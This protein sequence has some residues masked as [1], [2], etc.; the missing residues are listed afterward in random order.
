MAILEEEVWTGLGGNKIQHFEKLGYEIPRRIGRDGK[1]SVPKKLKILVK[2]KDLTES[3]TQLVTKICDDCG[4]QIPNKKYGDIILSRKLGDGRDRCHP[5]GMIYANNKQKNNVK[6][7]NSLE[8]Y[9]KNNQKEYLINEFS[10]K[11]IKRPNE[12]SSGSE[13]KYLWDCF[14]CKGEYSSQVYSRTVGSGCPYCSGRKVLIGFND[15]WTTHPELAKLLKD[16]KRGFEVTHGS[17]KKEIFVC[18]R[19]GYEQSKMLGNVSRQGFSC[20]RCSDGIKYPEK[21]LISFLDQLNLDYEPQKI[22][23]W[24]NNKRYD[25]YIRS[26]NMIIEVHGEQHYSGIG[27]SNLSGKTVKDEQKNDKYKYEMAKANNINEFIVL[28]CR[29]SNLNFIRNSILNSK[30]YEIFDL[31]RINWLKCHEFACGTIVKIISDLWNDG[32]K[33]TTEIGTILKMDSA[34]ISKYLKQGNTLGWCTYN[35]EEVKKATGQKISKSLRKKPVIQLTKDGEYL[36][37]WGSPTEAEKEMGMFRGAVSGVC[38]GEKKT[39]YGFK[40]IYKE[41]YEKQL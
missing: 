18:D 19:C 17:N 2:V 3:S 15:F 6:Y 37:T 9:A 27:F 34:T 13:E 7:E 11:N 26:Y 14:E 38:T 8:Y 10:V 31:Q 4:K 32:I 39:S 23:S 24:S 30:L 20:S 29:E 41:D 40:W 35:K 25:F 36:K 16:A 12:I 22:F 28:D 5:C 1:L 33:S 21:I